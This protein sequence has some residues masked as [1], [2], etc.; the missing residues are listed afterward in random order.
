[1]TNGVDNNKRRFLTIAATS[2]VASVGAVGAAV[3]PECAR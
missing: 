3:E 2:A 1:M